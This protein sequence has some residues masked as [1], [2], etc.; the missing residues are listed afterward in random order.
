MNQDNQYNNDSNI[1]NAS[2]SSV[3]A[4]QRRHDISAPVSILAE[5]CYCYGFI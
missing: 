3:P 5:F 2:S 4:S 1:N